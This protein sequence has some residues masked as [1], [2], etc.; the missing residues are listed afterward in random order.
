MNRTTRQTFVALIAVLLLAPLPALYGAEKLTPT[1]KP[2][3]LVILADD[4]Y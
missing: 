1:G 4:K 3:V 2:N